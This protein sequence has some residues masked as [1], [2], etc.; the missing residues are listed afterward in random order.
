MLIMITRYRHIE[1]TCQRVKVKLAQAPAINTTER[2]ATTC[3]ILLKQASTLEGTIGVVH[4]EWR[5]FTT[6][7]YVMSICKLIDD[8]G[9]FSTYS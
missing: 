2:Y 1:R 3:A 5:I 9:G 7:C 4:T 8:E 6:T